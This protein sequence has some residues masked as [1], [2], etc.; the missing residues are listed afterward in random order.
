MSFN[1]F[2]KGISTSV[3]G[4]SLIEF[5]QNMNKDI[6]ELSIGL[7]LSGI[8]DCAGSLLATY[9]LDK[10]NRQLQ[11]A[12]YMFIFSIFSFILPFCTSFTLYL[13]I[14]ILQNLATPF[15]F[16]IPSVWIVELFYNRATSYLQIMH[17]LFPVGEIIGSFLMVCFLKEDFSEFEN[18][19]NSTS[20]NSFFKDL[21]KTSQYSNLWIPYSIIAFLKLL[22]TILVI[23]AFLIK[24]SSLNLIK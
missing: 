11:Y 20:Q 22:I 2:Q 3:F 5:S 16:I 10:F 14:S 23:A 21:F 1:I 24:V 18:S 15:L 13:F 4:L 12:F 9:L 19:K 17:F 8:S 7:S 6:T